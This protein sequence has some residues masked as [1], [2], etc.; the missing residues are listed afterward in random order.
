MPDFRQLGVFEICLAAER[1]EANVHTY[2]EKLVHLRKLD[3]ELM[4]HQLYEP[5]ELYDKVCALFSLRFF[6]IDLMSKMFL[7]L[8]KLSHRFACFQVALKYVIGCLYINFTLLWDPVIQLI[9]SHA[10]AMDRKVFW[11]IWTPHLQSSAA[12]SGEHFFSECSQ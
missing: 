3:H 5:T 8:R 9:K 7:D 1:T 4:R 11:D 6:V 12:A 2:R 10:V